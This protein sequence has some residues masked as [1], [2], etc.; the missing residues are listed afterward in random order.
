[1]NYYGKRFE[2]IVKEVFIWNI[3]K[4]N[5]RKNRRNRGKI[6]KNRYLCFSSK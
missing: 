2:K 5:G 3:R 4:E 6:M 1:M